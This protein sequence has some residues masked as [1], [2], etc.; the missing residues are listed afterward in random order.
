MDLLNEYFSQDIKDRVL[1]EYYSRFSSDVEL[2]TS[3][4]ENK[5]IGLFEQ[6]TVEDTPSYQKYEDINNEDEHV[7]M[8]SDWEM[9]DS[10]IDEEV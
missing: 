10:I 2:I 3:L 8:L 7:A 9:I 4:I 6:E 1:F 5:K